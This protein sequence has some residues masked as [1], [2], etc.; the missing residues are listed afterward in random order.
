MRAPRAASAGG[1]AIVAAI[2]GILAYNSWITQPEKQRARPPRIDAAQRF[3]H[4]AYVAKTKEIS[5][6]ETLRLVVLPHPTG[7]D[8][9]DTKCL[10]YTHQE[11]RTSSI[12][13]PDA[14]QGD[15]EEKP[16]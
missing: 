3:E 7:I 2:A 5:P 1:I 13:C 16:D 15:I 10:I 14:K 12:L 8:M 9:L 6:G 4:W 11:F